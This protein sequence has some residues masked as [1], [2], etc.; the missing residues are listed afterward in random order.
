MRPVQ[1]T[2]SRTSPNS[3]DAQPDISSS[4]KPLLDIVLDHAIVADDALGPYLRG[5]LNATPIALVPPIR[6]ALAHTEPQH[7]FW[8]GTGNLTMFA[9]EAYYVVSTLV[10]VI[11]RL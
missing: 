3:L 7:D 1:M 2:R 8:Y 9:V 6:R 10:H 4:S 5:A 11:S